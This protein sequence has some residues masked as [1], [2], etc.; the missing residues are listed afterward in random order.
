M[1]AAAGGVG[2]GAAETGRQLA[3]GEDLDPRKIGKATYS[4]ALIGG[5]AVAPA[6]TKSLGKFIAAGQ[7]GT[8]AVGAN[9]F[10]AGT[11]G[12]GQSKLG[13]GSALEGFAGG[14]FGSIGGSA[15]SQALGPLAED[16]VASTVIAAGVGAGTAEL[17]GGDPLAGAAGGV[18]GALASTT[19]P[20]TGGSETPRRLAADKTAVAGEITVASTEPTPPALAEPIE[21]VYEP[22]P[23]GRVSEPEPAGRVTEPEQAPAQAG[24]Q[25]VPRRSDYTPPSEESFGGSASAGL[26]AVSLRARKH[27]PRSGG[28]RRPSWR[29][30]RRC[31]SRSSAPKDALPRTSFSACSGTARG[32][33]LLNI[34]S[35]IL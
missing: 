20:H 22:E 1:R 27:R 28:P 34:S 5:S 30:S 14:F 24:S 33:R 31:W 7:E 13:G 32:L 26:E 29:I 3:A 21:R 23:A 15:T 4:G 2:A 9:A 25:M 35:N 12:A 6:A 16:K 8:A 17:T 11:I 18:S 10:A 19:V